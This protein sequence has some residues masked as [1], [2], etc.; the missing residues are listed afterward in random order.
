MVPLRSGVPLPQPPGGEGQRVRVGAP[1]PHGVACRAGGT[2]LDPEVVAQLL[3]R[4]R[5]DPIDRLTP[6]S[7]RCWA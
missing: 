7:S 4:H 1:D 5:D 3:V 2:A 6:A